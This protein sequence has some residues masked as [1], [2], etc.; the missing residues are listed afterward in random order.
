MPPVSSS[1]LNWNFPLELV[2]TAP[3]L[4]PGGTISFDIHPSK[5]VSPFEPF[6][7][8]PHRSFDR[9]PGLGALFVSIG[10]VF[11][12]SMCLFAVQYDV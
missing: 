8:F 7:V 10:R 9:N 6:P 12:K 2:S 5:S 1:H 3:C 11:C 4:V